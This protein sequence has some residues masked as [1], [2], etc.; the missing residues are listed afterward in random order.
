MSGKVKVKFI[1]DFAPY[2]IKAGAVR[3]VS[4]AAARKLLHVYRVIEDPFA[5]KVI[6]IR[7]VA[8][9]REYGTGWYPNSL[10]IITYA[11]GMKLIDEGRAIL[12]QDNGTPKGVV[13]HQCNAF[14]PDHTNYEGVSKWLESHNY[15]PEVAITALELAM[16]CSRS[17]AVSV[18]EKITDSQ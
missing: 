3:T 11:D 6:L 14:C 16:Q 9:A 7:M 5:P 12:E 8:W 18:Y 10:H 13:D 15:T 4:D 1:A 2:G 17:R